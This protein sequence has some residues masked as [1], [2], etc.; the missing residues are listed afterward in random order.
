MIIIIKKPSSASEEPIK[1]RCDSRTQRCPPPP[2]V[3]PP[4]GPP[5]V[6]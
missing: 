2:P 6:K 5:I 1:E 3:N 4:I